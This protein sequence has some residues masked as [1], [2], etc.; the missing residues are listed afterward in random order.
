MG[1]NLANDYFDHKTG[2][3]EANLNPT[4]FSGGSRV[5]QEGLIPPGNVLRLSLFSFMASVFIGL[6]LVYLLGFAVLLLG[7]AGVFL[8]YFYTAPP[9]RLG[10]RG[11]GEIS[12]GLGFGPLVVAGSYYV[13]ALAFSPEAIL[14]S[15][16][17]GIL[18][19]LV[20]FINEFQDYDADRKVGKKTSVVVL[21]KKRAVKVYHALLAAAYIWVLAGVA[22]GVFPVFS[23]LV[24]LSLPAAIKAVKVSGASYGK[25]FELL[26]AN[27]STI[28]TH[29]LFGS[30]LVV[31]YLL[32]SF[33]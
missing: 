32:A 27:A 18:I 21:G 23:L 16:P 31:S 3:D 15:V 14:I 22:G 7:I 5:I 28:L 2:N 9:F 1:T 25:I 12:V 19:G 11:G 29:L 33:L 13:Q 20:L 24:F 6:W 26:P 30:L 10:Y 17:V 8:G 4:P